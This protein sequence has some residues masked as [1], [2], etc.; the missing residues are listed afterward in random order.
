MVIGA[1]INQVPLIKAARREGYRTIACDLDEHAP[2]APLA[3]IFL[4]V[5][6]K[7]RE[8]LLR[9]AKE[10]R[11]RGIAANSEYAM[12]DAAY[13]ANTLGLVGNPEEAVAILSSKSRFRALQKETG[14]YAP[15]FLPIDSACETPK[16]PETLSFPIL[17]KPDQSSGSRGM[18]MIREPA[19]QAALARA[20]RACTAVSRNGKALL[21]EYVRMPSRATVE[22]EIFLHRGEILWDGLFT[23]IRS[24]KAEQLPMTYVFPLRETEERIR[25]VKDTLARAFAA[26]GI[27]HG[28]YNTELFFTPAGEPFLLE[29][30]PRQGGYHLPEYVREHCGIDYHR[31]LVTT[32]MG[33][34]GYWNSLKSAKRTRRL[35]THHM[36]FPGSAGIFEG[37]RI[38]DSLRD[39]VYRTRLDIQKG[40]TVSG[41]ADASS[42]I[43]FA[44]LCFE[45]AE[46]QMQVSPNLEQLIQVE[47]GKSHEH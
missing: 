28:E 20:L 45:S 42:E 27:L 37:I 26:A 21:E 13:I 44:D 36:L 17:V 5:S 47:I 12:C 6:T 9:A 15:A 18:A 11:I 2:G 4:R 19:D 1:G 33:E 24:E 39:K 16:I 38:P 23:T 30:N 3:D 10:N 8:G 46:E 32:A 43:G 14:L 7:D 29:I 25:Q 35:I 34:D 41:P 40:T 31:L 22:G